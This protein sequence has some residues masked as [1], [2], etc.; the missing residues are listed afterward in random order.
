MWCLLRS[1]NVIDEH[2]WQREELVNYKTGISLE[3]EDDQQK[4]EDACLV[5]WNFPLSELAFGGFWLPW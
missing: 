4:K 1:G 3:L 2:A 5:S